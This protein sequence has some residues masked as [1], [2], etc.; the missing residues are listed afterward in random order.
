MRKSERTVTVILPTYNEAG[1]ISR[2]IRAI[3]EAMSPSGWRVTIHVVDDDSPDGTGLIAKKAS[4]PNLAVK[5]T[6]R[7]KERGLASALLY[8]I[9]RATTRY[10][11]LMDSD[12]N[13]HPKYIPEM[14]KRIEADPNLVV[15]GSRYMSG[16]GMDEKE[17]FLGSQF[18]NDAM[19]LVLGMPITDYLSGFILIKSKRLRDMPLSWIFRGFGE[20]ALRLHVVLQKK[21]CLVI[22]IPVYYPA[23]TY[24]KT[25]MDPLRYAF[26]L[27]KTLIEVNF[28]VPKD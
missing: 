13:H 25:K 9:R 22:E 19:K 7:K 1:N 3:G 28:L 23:R 6:I 2:L 12:F 27:L 24:G 16:G 8:G 5:V 14:F 4:K 11:L 10:I 18:L 20:W 17:R 26:A 21:K 15:S